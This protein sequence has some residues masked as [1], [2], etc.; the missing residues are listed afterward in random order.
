M[1]V[2][3][4]QAYCSNRGLTSRR[5]LLAQ[6]FKGRDVD[7]ILMHVYIILTELYKSDIVANFLKAR[8]FI[9]YL[10]EISMIAGYTPVNI[11]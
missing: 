8:T 4:G 5:I 10:Y 9:P 3:A 7:Q 6:V 11:I 1:T 2:P